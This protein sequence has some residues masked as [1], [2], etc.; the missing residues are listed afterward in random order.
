[1][2]NEKVPA[3]LVFSNMQ[4]ELLAEIIILTTLSAWDARLEVDKHM[5]FTFSND[6]LVQIQ[7][8]ASLP[9]SIANF[10]MKF[11]ASH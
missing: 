4:R 8:E 10:L 5:L 3:T 11:E 7:W 2:S 6:E 9:N 1:M